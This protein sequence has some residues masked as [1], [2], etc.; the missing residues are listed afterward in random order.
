MITLDQA[1]TI[2]GDHGKK[3]SDEE[4]QSIISFLYRIS[5]RVI[6]AIIC[7]NIALERPKPYN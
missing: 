6:N 4:I 7:N 1:K 3:L 2:L 5:D